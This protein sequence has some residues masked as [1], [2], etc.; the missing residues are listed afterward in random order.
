M[1]DVEISYNYAAGTYSTSGFSRRL[2]L[3]P[4]EYHAAVS[5]ATYRRAR[6][7]NDVLMCQRQ[8]KFAAD[9]IHRQSSDAI[10]LNFS[11]RCA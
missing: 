4:T 3:Y 10:F 7:V 2:Y 8:G 9:D 6:H 1:E 11:S 5:G